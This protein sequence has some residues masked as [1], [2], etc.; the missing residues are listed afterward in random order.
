MRLNVARRPCQGYEGALLRRTPK[1]PA[2]A[3]DKF[4]IA[5]R[6]LV[7]PWLPGGPLPPPFCAIVFR[8]GARVSNAPT[9]RGELC[10]R[11]PPFFPLSS[12]FPR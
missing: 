2:T 10:P 4:S 6:H 5:G 8:E 1:L 12:G 7:R 9:D 11:R 3:T